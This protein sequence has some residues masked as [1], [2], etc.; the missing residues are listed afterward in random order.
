[1]SFEE[2]KAHSI[3]AGRD[4]DAGIKRQE[5]TWA[6]MSQ[7]LLWKALSPKRLEILDTMVGQ[8]PMSIRELARR[9]PRDVKAVHADVQ[10][11]LEAKCI[12][13]T[14]DGR[15]ELPYDEVRL[16]VAMKSQA[17]A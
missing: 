10:S 6:F 17:A 1:M 16:E 3:A 13:K 8:G 5:S 12:M 9:L 4:A 7:E 11:L 14:P 15:I 2:M